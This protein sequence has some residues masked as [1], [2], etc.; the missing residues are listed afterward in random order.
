MQII[1]LFPEA[2]QEFTVHLD[3][4]RYVLRFKAANGVMV[5][6]VII[7]DVLV[8][9]GSRILAGEPLIPYE[10]LQ[11]GNFT[12]L[13]TNDELP[14]WREFG[15]TQTLIYASPAELAAL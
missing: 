6:D 10:Y 7:D 12:V 14:D 8:L 13:T 2:N 5:A 3:G 1:P 9:S 15:A 11:V 4:T